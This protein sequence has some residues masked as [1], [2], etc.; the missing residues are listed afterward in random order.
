YASPEQILGEPITTAT[1]VYALGTI[2]YELLT[3]IRPFRW[4]SGDP[5]EIVRLICEQEP[6]LPSRAVRLHSKVDAARGPIGGQ[7]LR[8]E[9][10]AIVMRALEKKPGARYPT[11]AALIEDVTRYLDG[12]PVIARHATLS[13]RALK[14]TKRHAKALTVAAVAVVLVSVF[15]AQNVLSARRIAVERDRAEASLKFLISLF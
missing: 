2:L 14:F 12:R 7:R 8:G 11:V 6:E 1:D 3:G 15:I 13:Y 9:L 5:R 4:E 10:D